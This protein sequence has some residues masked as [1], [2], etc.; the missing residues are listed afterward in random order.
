MGRKQKMVTD[1]KMSEN[2]VAGSFLLGYPFIPYG[3]LTLHS[4]RSGDG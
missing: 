1:D 3:K 2:T 4:R